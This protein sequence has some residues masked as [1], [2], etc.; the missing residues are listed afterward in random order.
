[1]H[2]RKGSIDTVD[3]LLKECHCDPNCKS[4]NGAT[5]LLVVTSLEKMFY[6]TKIIKLLLQ[7]GAVAS[8][9]YRYQQYLPHGTPMEPAQSTVA[10]FMVGDKGAGKSTLT[11]ALI[12]EKEGISGWAAKRFK[13]G[14]VKEKTAG[15]ECHTIHSSRIGSLTIYDLAGH[16]EFHNSHDTVIRNSISGPASGMFLCVFD[17]RAS[18]G[19]LKRTVSYWLA[20]IQNQVRIEASV[21]VSKPYVIAVGSHADSVRPKTDLEE[22]K[23]LLQK[24]CENANN[25][26][27][28]G[29]VAVDC[30][31]SESQSLTQLRT[32]MQDTH[33]K[34]QSAVPRMTCVAHCLH[35]YIISNCGSKPGMKLGDLVK[36]IKS[37]EKNSILPDT[38]ES[39]HTTCSNLSKMGIL[40]YIQ[41]NSKESSWIVIDRDMLLRE[42]NG[43]I[44]APEDFSEYKH[45]TSTG[46]VPFSKICGEFKEKIDPQLIVDF[47]VHMEFCQEIREEDLLKLVTEARTKHSTDKHFLFPALT[48]PHPPSDVWQQHPTEYSSCWVLRCLDQQYFTPRFHQVLLL[49]LGFEHADALEHQ[50]ITPTSPVLHQQCS[51]WRSGIKWTTDSCDVLVEISDHSVVLLLSCRKEVNKKFKELELISTRATVI[52]QILKAKSEFCGSTTTIEEFIPNSKYPVDCTQTP[53][54]SVGHIALAICRNKENIQTAPHTLVPILKVFQFEPYHFCNLQCLV[55]LYSEKLKSCKVTSHFIESMSTNIS[56]VDNFCKVLNVPL[57]K[58]VVDSNKSSDQHKVARMFREWQ[59]QSE[60]TY[61]CLRQHMDK[62]SVFSGRNIVVGFKTTHLSPP[63]VLFVYF[64]IHIESS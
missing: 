8:D 19:D 56:C 44:F 33:K 18:L 27:F 39:L 35:V 12:T 20:F 31:Y 55:D 6:H 5:P 10:V 32:H 7:C 42:V 48:Q 41:R 24:S 52:S 21:H 25:V 15:I 14:A 9:L 23:M 2:Y 62:Y 54:I 46:V 47:L 37:D 22:K 53:R 38:I 59:S 64:S 51:I 1:M 60:G 13:L 40:L 63:Y 49:R 26:V 34:L 4:E 17:L 36:V 11:K 61:Q 50:N 43:S 3:Y 16:R 57:H 29:Y 58:V 30:R 45:L 28:V